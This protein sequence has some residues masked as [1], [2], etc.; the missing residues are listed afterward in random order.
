[1]KYFQQLKFFSK[2]PLGGSAA[3]VN[4]TLIFLEKRTKVHPRL[5]GTNLVTRYGFPE[6]SCVIPNKSAYLDD[7]TWERLVKVVAPV[8]RKILVSNFTCVFPILFSI[9]LTIHIC[10]SILS[11]DDLWF[12]KVVVIPHIWWLQ[13]SCEC[14]W[15]PQFF[16]EGRIKAGK[17]ESG[18]STFNQ[19]Y[20]KFQTNNDKDQTRQILDLAR[21]KFHGQINQWQLIMI[22]Y[23]VIQNIPAKVW[24]DY[25]VAVNLH[26]HHRLSFS[27]WIKN[28]APADKKGETAYFWNYEV[29]FNDALP[30]IWKH[31]TV[32]KIR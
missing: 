24:I 15:C 25:F 27:G 28:N 12:P 29:F 17:E 2:S 16:S 8:I 26:S 1:M 13:V 22:S 10:P 5:R 14:H 4:D 19:A 30:S 20:D 32:L 18:T 7:E 31:M 23:T 21:R 9:Y 11:S 3:S 6:G